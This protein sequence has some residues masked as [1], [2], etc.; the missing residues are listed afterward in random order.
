MVRRLLFHLFSSHK[1]AKQSK[2]VI[3]YIWWDA[4]LQ[5]YCSTSQQCIP[6]NL[7][8][9]HAQPQLPHERHLR[10]AQQAPMRPI[11][12]ASVTPCWLP[13]RNILPTQLLDT[14]SLW[15][16]SGS[17]WG[18]PLCD[19]PAV[20]RTPERKGRNSSSDFG[21]IHIP[22]HQFHQFHQ[23]HPS[24]KL[25]KPQPE[26]TSLPIRSCSLDAAGW[27]LWL[28][29]PQASKAMALS[30]KNPPA[31][32]C[33]PCSRDQDFRCWNTLVVQWESCWWLWYLTVQPVFVVSG[34]QK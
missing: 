30:R 17:M 6:Q 23:F 14:S 12:G 5:A 3:W 32:P 34:G 9:A 8:L 1:L 15:L 25:F 2:T 20:S 29:T 13:T 24:P 16:W 4:T 26:P 22:L 21:G 10:H 33:S 28:G 18:P 11:A 31:M 7:S 19:N 27:K